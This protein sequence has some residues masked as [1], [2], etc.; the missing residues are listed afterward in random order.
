MAAKSIKLIIPPI[1]QIPE[2]MKNTNQSKNMILDKL[3]GLFGKVYVK[4]KQIRKVITKGQK[5]PKKLQT[6]SVKYT[7]FRSPNL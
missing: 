7:C 6:R 4:E 2:K 3:S 1:I 5:L